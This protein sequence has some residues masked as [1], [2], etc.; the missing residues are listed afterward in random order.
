M[1]DNKL[2]AEA[3]KPY[4]SIASI[5]CLLASL[6]V[7]RLSAGVIAPKE[8]YTG[9]G[10]LGTAIAALLICLAIGLL[11]GL[12]GLWRAEK[13]GKLSYFAILANAL[14]I[15]WLMANKPG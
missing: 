5:I 3:G 13:P 14:A 10:G 6:P 9:Y 4:F 8:D 12:V 1:E 2:F 11:L 7:A 15:A